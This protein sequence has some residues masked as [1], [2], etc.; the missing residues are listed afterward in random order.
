MPKKN[1]MQCVIRDVGKSEDFRNIKFFVHNDF[2]RVMLGGAG[3]CYRVAYGV[4]GDIQ[5]IEFDV[6]QKAVAE[7]L[8]LPE[9]RKLGDRTLSEKWVEDLGNNS[10]R[11]NMK[12]RHVRGCCRL[13]EKGPK[14]VYAHSVINIWKD[15]DSII[16]LVE[17]TGNKTVLESVQIVRDTI[18]NYFQDIVKEW[19]EKVL[20]VGF[21][22]HD[23]FKIF[24]AGKYNVSLL[25]S[26]FN[27]REMCEKMKDVYL[28]VDGDVKIDLLGVYRGIAKNLRDGH[29]FDISLQEDPELIKDVSNTSEALSEGVLLKCQVPFKDQETGLI[30]EKVLLNKEAGVYLEDKLGVYIQ[31]NKR[32]SITTEQQTKEV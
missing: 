21:S 25:C 7:S 14:E 26:S 27:Y 17:E 22:S 6:N 18:K 15:L 1:N 16:A 29:K 31:G 9:K 4:N 10:I 12:K 23:A 20:D 24:D 13:L 32:K 30:K 11:D 5:L 3:I 8:A 19:N 28:V 2:A